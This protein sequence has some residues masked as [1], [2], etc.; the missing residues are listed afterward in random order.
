MSET[1]NRK[2]QSLL[3]EWKN[4]SSDLTTANK[5]KEDFDSWI[6]ENSL[7]KLTLDK[8]TNLRTNDAVDYFT[9]WLE[10]KTEACGKFRTASSYA[11][12][13][14]RVKADGD[15][16]KY[17]SVEQRGNDIFLNAEQAQKYF[18]NIS[19]K[20]IALSKF[21]DLDDLSP[22]E[23]NFSRKV[24]YMFN[25]DKLIPIYKRET[26]KAIAEYFEIKGVEFD[27]YKASNQIL[28][29]LK[30]KGF[31]N[32]EGEDAF[33]FTQRLGTFLWRKF[34][35]PPLP[36]LVKHKNTIYFGAPGTGKT[37][38]VNEDIN[39]QILMDGQDK[40]EVLEKAQFHPSYSYEDF[41]DGLKPVMTENGSIALKLQSGRFKQLCKKAADNLKQKRKDG[42]EPTK[43]YFFADEIN[44]AELSRVLGEVLVCLEDSKRLDF[45]N[46]GN[47]TTD[48][49]YLKT[50]YS[51]LDSPHQAVLTINNEH[52]FGVPTNLYFVG[53]MND[54]DRSIDSFDLA[55]RRRFVWIEMKCNY[56]VIKDEVLTNNN[57]NLVDQYDELCKKL[58]NTISEVWGL[59]SSYEI[60][61]AY[62]IKVGK[63]TKANL[64]ELFDLQIAPL[65]KE[66]LRAEYSTPEI[67]KKLKEVKEA[68]TLKKKNTK[69]QQ[70]PENDQ[71]GQQE[72]KG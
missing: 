27:L 38:T 65:L 45:D 9:H 15:E 62:F 33:N 13:I 71:Q 5:Q 8:Y 2:W 57:K 51:H 63:L 21:N 26:L 53:T 58:N 35:I 19:P 72:L 11:Y 52:Y 56:D 39:M 41:I 42:E 29:D 60:G 55:L 61:H 18:N 14:Y 47:P 46:E 49:F 54:I 16:V 66:Y 36:P 59:G 31:K 67:E 28:N 1:E 40:N 10:R 30:E 23:I 7:D 37:Y 20:L 24:A 70:E 64:D 43:F 22:L 12:G 50:Q 48:S 44:R 17:K 4:F 6:S 3:D 32:Q 34:G 25:P 69:V 68:F